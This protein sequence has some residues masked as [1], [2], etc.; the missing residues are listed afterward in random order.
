MCDLIF[1]KIKSSL[2]QL[3]TYRC[4]SLI[5]IWQTDPIVRIYSRSVVGV[6]RILHDFYIQ[7]YVSLKQRNNETFMPDEQKCLLTFYILKGV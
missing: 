3:I 6:L 5:N 4:F 7:P 1:K 2:N